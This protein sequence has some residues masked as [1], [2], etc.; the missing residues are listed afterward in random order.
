LPALFTPAGASGSETQHV[1]M[2]FAGGAAD[3]SSGFP[4][5]SADGRFVA[6]QSAAANLVSGDLNRAQD[7]F[8]YDRQADLTSRVS[9]SSAAGQAEGDSYDPAISAD[10]RFVAFYSTAHN[11]VPDDGNYG[12]DVFVHDRRTGQTSRVSVATGGAEAASGSSAPALS[13]DGRYVAFES[14]ADNL[15]AGDTNYA[16]DIFVHDRQTGATSRVSVASG[17]EEADGFSRAPA[18]SADG[19]YV[20]FHSAATNL[21]EGD[22]NGVV[23]IFVHDRQTGQTS[24]VSLDSAGVQAAMDA[25]QA[26]LSADGRFVAFRSAAGN[27]VPGDSNDSMDVFVHDR[28]TGQTSRVSVSAGGAQVTDPGEEPYPSLAISGDGRYVAFNSAAP[29]LVAGDDNGG[30]DSFVHDRQTGTTSLVSVNSSGEQGN[31]AT[32]NALALSADGRYVAFQ[33]G[34]TNLS[35]LDT[36]NM[37]NIFVHDRETG[38]TGLASLDSN[39]R[40]RPPD[41][42]SESPSVAADGRYV[43]FESLASN[44]VP[45]D[46]NTVKDIFIHDRA[47]RQTRLISVSSAGAQGDGASEKG[48]ISADGR[49][50]A[51]LSAAANLVPSDTNEM[52]DVFVHDLQTGQTSR[53]SVSSAGAQGNGRCYALAI[54]ADGRTVA[55][56]SEAS[57]LVSGDSN[58]QG[59]VFVHERGTGVTTRVSVASDGTQTNLPSG[60]PALSADGR[61]VAF[62]SFASNLVPGDKNQALDIFVHDRST[63]ATTRV[64]VASNGAEGDDSATAPAISADGRYVAFESQASNLVP[65]D[66]DYTTDVFVHDRQTQQTQLVSVNSD[67]VRGETSSGQPSL[68]A[69]GR[70]VAFQ[71]DAENLVADDTNYRMDIFVH[72]RQTKRTSRV[73]VTSAGEQAT[74]YSRNAAISANG[75]FVAFQSYDSFNLYLSPYINIFLHDRGSL[76]P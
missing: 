18:I 74:G 22:T 57:N 28:Q 54:S 70:Y 62:A 60:R 20:A 29:D 50:V 13:A 9:V 35:A 33:S 64:S 69:D 59:D 4:A 11:L 26:A 71:S 65:G 72:D 38:A 66:N 56:A 37:W 31:E 40:D 61:I 46:K 8:V 53:V 51:F 75:R 1:S 41:D 32:H 25:D 52:E 7:I 12:E 15:V 2:A 45:G 10:G 24:R 6:F 19:R 21:V 3:S 34:S 27:L 76:A 5:L 55:F 42:D 17:G 30:S 49:T 44:L 47:A 73:S 23:D 36:R 43:V 67:G 58:G 68:S 16:T 63:G 39:V 14:Y 48:V